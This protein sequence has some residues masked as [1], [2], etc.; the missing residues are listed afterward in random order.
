MPTYDY[1]CDATG[2]VFEVHHPMARTISNWGELC[3][4]AEI[5][6][7]DIPADSS[8]SKLLTSAG[9]IN[10]RTLKNPD[11]PACAKANGC[12]SCDFM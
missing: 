9:V 1:R 4:T 8:V 6:P 11:A 12:G 10:S 3:E 2:K 7:A 5:D